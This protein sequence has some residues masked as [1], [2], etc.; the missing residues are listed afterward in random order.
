MIAIIL[1]IRK[2]GKKRRAGRTSEIVDKEE[3]EKETEDKEAESFQDIRF[4]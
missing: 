4:S 1:L 2:I 3:F